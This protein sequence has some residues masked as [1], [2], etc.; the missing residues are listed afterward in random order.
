MARARWTPKDQA[1]LTRLRERGWTVARIRDEHYPNTPLTT[2]YRHA[3][4][5]PEFYRD[6][7][8]TPKRRANARGGP[9]RSTHPR[10]DEAIE[11]LYARGMNGPTIA[12]AL[13]LT[14][15]IVSLRIANGSMLA[16]RHTYQRRLIENCHD[17]LIAGGIDPNEALVRLDAEHAREINGRPAQEDDR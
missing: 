4:K 9:V 16:A 2:L 14:S 6:P 12:R 1:K 10:V 11:Y 3:H 13:D 5:A 15:R 17:D 8:A 7:T